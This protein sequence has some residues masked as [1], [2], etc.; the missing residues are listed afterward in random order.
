MGGLKSACLVFN[1]AREGAFHM[2]EQFAFQ[3]AVV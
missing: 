3:Q 1:R 2:P